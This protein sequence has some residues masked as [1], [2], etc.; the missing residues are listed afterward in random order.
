MAISSV[1]PAPTIAAL[2]RALSTARQAQYAHSDACTTCNA[3]RPCLDNEILGDAYWAALA[4]HNNAV[5]A[6][7]AR[8]RARTREGLR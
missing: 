8:M 7:N 5:K 1:A 2:E 3:L 6:E 4:A